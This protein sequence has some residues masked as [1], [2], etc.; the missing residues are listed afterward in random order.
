MKQ[1]FPFLLIFI[2]FFILF[3]MGIA[4]VAG[5]CFLLGIVM[6]ILRVWPE[7]WEDEKRGK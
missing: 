1:F 4:E 7:E 6:I 2:G 3:F 5:V